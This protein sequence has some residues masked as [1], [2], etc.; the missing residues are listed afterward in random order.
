MDYEKLRKFVSDHGTVKVYSSGQ[1][2]K[3]KSDDFDTIDLVEK[4]ERFE[5]EGKTYTKVEMEKLVAAGN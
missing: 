4:T 1:E 3:L 5:Y 2:R